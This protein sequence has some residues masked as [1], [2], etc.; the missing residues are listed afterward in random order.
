MLGCARDFSIL[1]N[2]LLLFVFIGQIRDENQIK[3]IVWLFFI[4]SFLMTLRD[5]QYLVQ[6]RG[7]IDLGNSLSRFIKTPGSPIYSQSALFLSI[8]LIT[9]GT[10]RMKVF[11]GLLIPLLL[12]VI[13]L[14]LTRGYWFSLSCS[15]ISLLAIELKVREYSNT[16]KKITFLALLTVAIIIIVLY[17]GFPITFERLAGRLDTSNPQFQL[18]ALSKYNETTAAISII[19]KQ[20]LFGQGLGYKLTYYARPW[21]QD[22]LKGTSTRRFIHNSYLFIFLKLGFIGLSFFLYFVFQLIRSV[23]GRYNTANW[24]FYKGLS[25][26]YLVSLIG[27]CI[28]SFS[29]AKFTEAPTTLFIGIFG[30]IILNESYMFPEKIEGTGAIK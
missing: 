27:I 9:Y 1:L 19:K 13:L 24:G 29:T 12:A 25:L 10:R 8:G 6:Q 4:L 26:G 5:L 16:V 15:F 23:Y 2:Y 20:P 11:L 21:Y 18:S 14:S 30:G 3:K 7:I 28:M 22:I 17:A